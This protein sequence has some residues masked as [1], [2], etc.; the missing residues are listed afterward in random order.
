M[1]GRMKFALESHVGTARNTMFRQACDSVKGQLDSMCAGTAQLLT[2]S[3]QDL[4]TKLRRDYLAAL[5][6]DF[7]D[8]SAEV[9][10]AER[11][12]RDQLRS[13]LADA[14]SR[15]AV[16]CFP[17]RRAMSA[18]AEGSQREESFIAQQLQ[19]SMGQRPRNVSASAMGSSV[20]QEP[21]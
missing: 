16:F 1:F 9:P 20:K 21:R 19:D 10:L 6:G 4:V 5:T 14:D 18:T 15:F 8:A 7:S 2:A 17:A 13:I 12:L 3:V 11:M